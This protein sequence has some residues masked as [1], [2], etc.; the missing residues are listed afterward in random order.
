MVLDG[1]RV[2]LRSRSEVV[3]D[4]QRRETVRC[5]EVVR[6]LRSGS[7]AVLALTAPKFGEDE[8]N[9]A[10]GRMFPVVVTESHV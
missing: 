1:R 7:M 8:T 10:V 9:R 4:G 2:C 6:R 5:W 3:V